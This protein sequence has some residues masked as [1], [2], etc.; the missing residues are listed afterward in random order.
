MVHKDLLKLDSYQR[1]IK[2]ESLPSDARAFSPA[3]SYPNNGCIVF[4]G[5]LFCR[6]I[7]AGSGVQELC[8]RRFSDRGNLIH[9]LKRYHP[10][11]Q[12]APVNCGRTTIQ[13]TTEARIFYRSLMVNAQERVLNTLTIRSPPVEQ[14]A[15]SASSEVQ[16]PSEIASPQ[17]EVVAGVEAEEEAESEEEEQIVAPLY[18]VNNIRRKQRK[19]D[20]DT[21]KCQIL[22]RSK[23]LP[24]LCN[25]CKSQKK[26]LCTIKGP[27]KSKQYFT[28]SR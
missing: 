26:K 11:V 28:F 7:W 6:A 27:C 2:L 8:G 19:G 1:Y 16:E 5:E 10:E 25:T 23:G 13:G 15:P 21:H 14:T 9:H 18:T 3:T 22:L 24:E 4:P 12:I 20:P 17:Q